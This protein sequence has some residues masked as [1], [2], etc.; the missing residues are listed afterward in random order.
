MIVKHASLLTNF[1]SNHN[2]NSLFISL[3]VW[4]KKL[5]WLC[6]CKCNIRNILKGNWQYVL[7]LAILFVGGL[8]VGII[9]ATNA[10]ITDAI[11]PYSLLKTGNYSAFK[12][13]F[14]YMLMSFCVCFF[15]WLNNINKLFVILSFS[16]IFYLGYKF[17]YNCVVSVQSAVISGILSIIIFYLPIFLSN[18]ISAGI[19]LKYA[20][21]NWLSCKSNQTCRLILKKAGMFC[22]INFFWLS[23]IAFFFTIILPSILKLILF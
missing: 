5:R 22:A 13:F 9:V 19:M 18:V 14:I 3:I 12:Y 17:G 20:S 4:R 1:K 11:S 6:F 23:G 21:F 16:I 2:F 15:L 7:W 10:Q 8:T